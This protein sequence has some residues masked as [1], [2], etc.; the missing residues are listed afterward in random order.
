MS[1]VVDLPVIT[2][3][4]IDPRRI[5]AKALEAGMTTVVVVGVDKD[6]NEFFASSIADG[7]DAL[8]HLERAKYR[9]LKVVDER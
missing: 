1:N 7:A 9:L 5:L 3:L 6:G 4:D 8:W 2:T